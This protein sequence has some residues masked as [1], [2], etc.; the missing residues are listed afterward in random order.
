MSFGKGAGSSSGKYTGSLAN[1]CPWY[2]RRV[3][4][5]GLGMG[6]LFGVIASSVTIPRAA[7]GSGSFLVVFL[8]LFFVSEA[9]RRVKGGLRKFN[10]DK[11]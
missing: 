8:F 1:A 7:V 10:G 4:S 6:V 2:V 11:G 5:T 9:S 3:L